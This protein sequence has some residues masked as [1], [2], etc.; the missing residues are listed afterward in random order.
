MD[1]A[2]RL[3]AEKLELTVVA[4]NTGAIEMYKKLGFVQEGYMKR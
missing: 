1:R 3:G 4:D 2:K